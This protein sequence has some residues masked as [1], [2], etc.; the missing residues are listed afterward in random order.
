MFTWFN[1]GRKSS[2]N[3][4]EFKISDLEYI[5]RPIEGCITSVVGRR[6]YQEDRYCIVRY[7][8]ILLYGVFDGHG[9]YK[10]AENLTRLLPIYI[11]KELDGINLSNESRVAA[12]INKAYLKLDRYFFDNEY[13]EGSTAVISLVINSKIYLINL[14]DSRCLIVQNGKV[15]RATQDHKPN[16]FGEISRIKST[17]S[18]VSNGIIPRV[19]GLLAVSRSFGDM[20]LKTRSGQKVYLGENAPVSPLPSVTKF[21]IP[22]NTQDI[23]IVMATDGLWDV[24]SNQEV[25]SLLGSYGSNVGQFCQAAIRAAEE[26]GSSD[27][28]TILTEKI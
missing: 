21:N 16:S 3:S 7:N 17:G 10:V 27:N 15:L 18:F 25:A 9:G 20:E 4:S 23:Y 6:P 12:A 11:F 26:R 1:M 14:G 19:G 13:A 5:D 8:D 28:I 22:S 24:L 2:T